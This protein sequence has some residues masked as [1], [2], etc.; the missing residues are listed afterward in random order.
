MIILTMSNS[1]SIQIKS[2]YKKVWPSNQEFQEKIT[3]EFFCL[4]DP[5]PEQKRP[6]GLDRAESGEYC[7]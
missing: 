3:P 5:T 2:F 6:A 1:V 4:T 7:S